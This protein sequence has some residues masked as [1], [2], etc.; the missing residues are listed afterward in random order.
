MLEKYS[1]LKKNLLAYKKVYVE[2][3]VRKS[4]HRTLGKRKTKDNILPKKSELILG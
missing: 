4:Y 2:C 1:E 3:S